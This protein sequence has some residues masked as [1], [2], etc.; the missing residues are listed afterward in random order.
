MVYSR[1]ATA[2]GH[3]RSAPAGGGHAN[4]VVS[5]A[6]HSVPA[7][8]CRQCTAHVCCSSGPGLAHTAPLALQQDQPN[9]ATWAQNEAVNCNSA[10][11]ARLTSGRA[12]RWRR[13]TE[14]APNQGGRFS[15]KFG[16]TGIKLGQTPA[17]RTRHR[18]DSPALVA[19]ARAQP[20]FGRRLAKR[21]DSSVCARRYAV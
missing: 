2:V 12:T 18:A 7:V 13:V 1:H 11:A 9:M 21:W 10:D 14:L 17:S 8:C 20:W 3:S 5:G 15:A 19:A 6:A 16:G 4:T